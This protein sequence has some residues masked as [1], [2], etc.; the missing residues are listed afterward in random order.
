MCAQI[1]RGRLDRSLWLAGGR[2][3]TARDLESSFTA[4][5][6]PYERLLHAVPQTVAPL[7]APTWITVWRASLTCSRRPRESAAPPRISYALTAATKQSGL[8][9]GARPQLRAL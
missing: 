2:I 4:A 5:E 7:V 1:V 8:P 6:P 3:A 9:F